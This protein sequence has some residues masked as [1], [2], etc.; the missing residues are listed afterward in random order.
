MKYFTKDLWAEMNQQDNSRTAKVK[1][2]WCKNVKVYQKYLKRVLPDLPKQV[3]NF[4]GKVSLHD[5]M[6]LSFSTGD[7]IKNRKRTVPTKNFAE[8]K[9]LEPNYKY[10]Y[11]LLY[12]EVRKCMIDYPGESPLFLG[13]DWTYGDWGYDE[14]YFTKDKWLCHE[15]LF[16]SGA[17]ILL[18]SKHF[19]YERKS[20]KACLDRR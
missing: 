6:L 12:S 10:I 20:S 4:F 9:I 13:E 8:I 11:T 5:G 16:S 18:E 14:L 15:I 17:T 7:K 19:S 2:Q 3:Q 1:S